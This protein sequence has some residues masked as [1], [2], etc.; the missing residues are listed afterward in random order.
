[1]N[2][3]DMDRELFSRARSGDLPALRELGTQFIER[4]KRSGEH[5]VTIGGTP[6][7]GGQHAGGNAVKLDG[8]GNIVGGNVPREWQGQHVQQAGRGKASGGKQ[9]PK[10]GKPV[11]VQTKKIGNR[12][13][14]MWNHP[15]SDVANASSHDDES[16]AT[17]RAHKA[18]AAAGHHVEGTAGPQP[19]PEATWD[20]L[21]ADATE[22][23]EE[24]VLDPLREQVGELDKIAEAYGDRHAWESAAKNG[25]QPGDPHQGSDGLERWKQIA[26]EEGLDP[27]LADS[28]PELNDLQ[29]RLA[30]HRG[31]GDE[32]TAG[33]PETVPEPPP[34]AGTLRE[35]T[36]SIREILPE[37]S[38]EAAP[39]AQEP[40]TRKPRTTPEQQA[41]AEAPAAQ[42]PDTR[43]PRTT[44]EQQAEAEAPAAQEPDTRKPRTTPEQ[45]AEAPAGQQSRDAGPPQD[46]ST[47]DEV[48]SLKREIDD[49]R[50]QVQSLQNSGGS[51]DEQYGHP[52]TIGVMKAADLSRDAKRFQYKLNVDA[53][54]VTSQFKD[55]KYNPELAGQMAVW[56]DP[57]TD[58]TF[59]INGHHRH[60]LAERSGFLGDMAVYHL[61]A[62]NE[63]EA[64]A[65]GALINIAGGQ[66]TAID[67]AKYFRESGATP[68]ELQADGVSLTKGKT[69]DA[70]ALRKLSPVLFEALALGIYRQGRALAITAHLDD[71]ADQEQIDQMIEKREAKGGP[72]I[73]DNVVGEMARQMALSARIAGGPQQSR[74]PGMEGTQDDSRST[75]VEKAEITSNIRRGMTGRL[76]KFKAVS[77]ARAAETLAGH[78]TIDAAANREEARTIATDL[79][80]FDRESVYRGPISD[81]LNQAA[82]EMANEPHRKTEIIGAAQSAISRHLGAVPEMDA[83]A[84]EGGAPGS[85]QGG[86]E[87]P[88]PGQRAFFSRQRDAASGWQSNLKR[89]I[90][91]RLSAARN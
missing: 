74:L 67:A 11:K 65:K 36:R 78:N 31:W 4:Y 89:H 39:A 77:N 44:P 87:G 38:P 45:Q 54:G 21:P 90:V 2:H 56:T 29:D 62:T 82:K 1:M 34:E 76:N 53:K 30:K 6:S 33:S 19:K 26:G 10:Q 8:Q 12:H 50:Q 75:L 13:Y 83:G 35:L 91:K 68:E 84:E 42:E 27:A 40:D 64:R 71:H 24:H 57:E 17:A 66:G 41:E 3:R 32:V 85:G 73:S 51:S 61:D 72:A 80:T 52:G 16:E 46:D 81:I 14:A 63:N 59:V 18:I 47:P 9:T 43:K 60:E 7:K 20:S 58:E 48:A 79:D 28:H 22:G 69:Q 86:W 23:F 15:E 55:V 25:V 37:Q 70:L 5:W 49:L 88:A